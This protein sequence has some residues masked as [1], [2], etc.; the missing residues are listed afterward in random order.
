MGG[1]L[2]SYIL[3]GN[4]RLVGSAQTDRPQDRRE[5]RHVAGGPP[6]AH[7]LIRASFVPPLA[8]QALRDLTRTRNQLRT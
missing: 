1:G 2:A 3:S 6:G 7:G 5:R 4:D 8:V